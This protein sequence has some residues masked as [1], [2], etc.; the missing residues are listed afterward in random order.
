M[1]SQPIQFPCLISL[2]SN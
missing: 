2:I 1:F